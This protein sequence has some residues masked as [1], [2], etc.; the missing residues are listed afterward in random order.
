MYLKF[1]ELGFPKT[2]VVCDSNWFSTKKY[3]HNL[4]VGTGSRVRV[5][6]SKY[7]RVKVPEYKFLGK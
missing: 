2:Y 4:Y 6:V 3:N 7:I 1:L 5:Q